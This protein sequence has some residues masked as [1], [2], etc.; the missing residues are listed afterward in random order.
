MIF[1]HLHCQFYKYARIRVWN[2]T[3]KNCYMR[4]NHLCSVFNST[5]TITSHLPTLNNYKTYINSDITYMPA[6]RYIPKKIGGKISKIGKIRKKSE[7]LMIHV[8]FSCNIIIFEIFSD[9]HLIKS[10]YQV[11]IMFIILKYRKL[12]NKYSY[13]VYNYNKFI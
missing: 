2:G 4:T 7:K 8:K 11:R 6:F 12:F 1:I 13:C 5:I 10:T 9:P 3:I